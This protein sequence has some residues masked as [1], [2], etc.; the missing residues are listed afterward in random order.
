MEYKYPNLKIFLYNNTMDIIIKTFQTHYKLP[1]LM[2][3]ECDWV[4]WSQDIETGSSEN[5]MCKTSRLE[6]NARRILLESNKSFENL[7]I[8]IIKF[9][10]KEGSIKN[11]NHV[12]EYEDSYEIILDLAIRGDL[13]D[14]Y[15]FKIYEHWPI[16]A[17]I[18]YPEVIYITQLVDH[19]FSVFHGVFKALYK[20]SMKSYDILEMRK[21]KKLLQQKE[22]LD[23]NY[24]NISNMI[25]D[26]IKNKNDKIINK[27]ILEQKII[28]DQL[29][30]LED[31]I[32]K[33]NI[34]NISN[35]IDKNL[36]LGEKYINGFVYNIDIL[37]YLIFV[38]SDVI[39]S[40]LIP[41][42]NIQLK[43]TNVEF[44]TFLLKK[45]DKII[46]Y[47]FKHYEICYLKKEDLL[48][49]EKKEKSSKTA[50]FEQM[51]TL[52]SAKSVKVSHKLEALFSN[53]IPLSDPLGE[54]ILYSIIIK[55]GFGAR[56][57]K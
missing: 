19:I 3:T 35:R 42:L 4:K 5:L 11:F 57:S 37:T 21:P 48:E 56:I 43:I 2:S 30:K 39:P 25:Q 50:T 6:E 41:E 31:E 18:M 27:L 49:F 13:N 36:I 55:L 8:S 54:A 28:K 52:L 9:H 47:S 44:L 46:R 32:L 1:E 38:N 53:Y 17:R 15:D 26:A 12:V 51:M 23:N 14:L 33:K 29:D 10:M 34:E 45:Y 22:V 7:I 24:K 40:K 16:N 20:A